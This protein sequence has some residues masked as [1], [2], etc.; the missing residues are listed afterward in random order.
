MEE[1]YLVCYPVYKFQVT[2][3][4]PRYDERWDKSVSVCHD[5]ILQINILV[6]TPGMHSASRIDQM[7]PSAPLH[8]RLWNVHGGRGWMGSGITEV[9]HKK[10]MIWSN[11]QTFSLKSLNLP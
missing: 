2:S 10:H 3:D 5:A 11:T 7:A 9:D 1:K 8:E 6:E 4:Q